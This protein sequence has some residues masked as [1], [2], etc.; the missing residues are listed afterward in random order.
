MGRIN[1][2]QKK[3][4]SKKC[5]FKKNVGSKKIW[6]EIWFTFFGV[7]NFVVVDVVL[8]IVVDG[9]PYRGGALLEIV[10]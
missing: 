3:I 1:L 2:V 4:C 10:M 8:D 9:T 7:S 5:W 6:F